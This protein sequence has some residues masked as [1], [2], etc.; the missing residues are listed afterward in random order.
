MFSNIT[1]YNIINER[2]VEDLVKKIGDNSVTLH[3]FRPTIVIKTEPYAEDEFEWVKTGDVIFR[4]AKPC[5][6]CALTTVNPETGEGN[7]NGDPLRTL[8]K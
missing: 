2:S 6:R 5:T 3:N 1:S 4:L 8:R 7:K